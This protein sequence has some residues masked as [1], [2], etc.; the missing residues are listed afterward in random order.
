LGPAFSLLWSIFSDFIRLGSFTVGC[1]SAKVSFRDDLTPKFEGLSG[2]LEGPRLSGN[3][4][5]IGPCRSSTNLRSRDVSAG[6]SSSSAAAAEKA[7]SDS[8]SSS[9]PTSLSGSSPSLSSVS[10]RA[11]FELSK[12][13]PSSAASFL[14]LRSC[15]S[16]CSPTASS[17]LRS[18]AVARSTA[19]SPRSSSSSVFWDA[20]ASP[21][22]PEKSISF[23]LLACL[24]LRG[25]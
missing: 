12:S 6:S 24:R 13:S 20:E 15:F 23:V 9:R 2:T 7:R 21:F 18:S 22:P 1:R 4:P 11:L 14:E 5:A 3:E 25:F 8:V 10:L 17:M 16:L 19:S